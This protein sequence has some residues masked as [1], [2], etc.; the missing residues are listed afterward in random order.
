MKLGS[1]ATSA[2]FV[3]GLIGCGAGVLALVGPNPGSDPSLA[4]PT[5]ARPLPVET[6]LV[7]RESSVVLPRRATG[8]LA[9]RRRVELAFEVA[10]EVREV[11]VDAGSAV[12]QGDVLA[13]LDAR[14]ITAR[15]TELAAQR[16]AAEALLD[17]LIKGPRKE[18]LDAARADLAARD[19]ELALVDARLVRRRDLAGGAVA[20]ETVLDLEAER[21]ARSAARAAAAAVL[22]ELQSGTRAERIA[23]QRATVEQLDAALALL[24]LDLD[25]TELHAPF[26]AIVAERLVDEG[27]LVNAG[28]P[29]LTLVEHGALEARFGLAPD[30]AAAALVEPDGPKLTLRGTALHFTAVRLLPDVD[31]ATRTRTLVFDGIRAAEPSTLPPLA[32]GETVELALDLSVAADGFWIPLAALSQGTRGLWSLFVARPSQS[33]AD[34]LVLDRADVEVLH[35]SDGRAFVRGTLADGDRAVLSGSQRLVP[36]QHV[37]LAPEALE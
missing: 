20:A 37:T 18:T 29:T 32:A 22:E 36:G 8:E 11:L 24:Q 13:R 17:E 16:R 28:T 7:R 19:A 3:V 9:A 33:H 15:R 10:G 1:L 14:R 26:D 35:I 27:A 25:D 23:A 30:V 2:L 31:R 5:A 21:A 6:A 4:S 12:R 34:R